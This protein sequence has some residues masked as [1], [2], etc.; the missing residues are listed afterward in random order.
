MALFAW[1]TARRYRSGEPE[2]SVSENPEAAA[3]AEVTD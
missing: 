3:D 2:G 1:R